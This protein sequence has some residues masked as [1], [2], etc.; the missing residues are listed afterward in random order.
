VVNDQ[1]VFPY[2]YIHPLYGY[3][4]TLQKPGVIM[5]IRLD[6]DCLSGTLRGYC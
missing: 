3:T 1:V 6:Y 2:T 5:I 4:V